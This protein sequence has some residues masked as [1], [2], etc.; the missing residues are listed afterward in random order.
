VGAAG[1]LFAMAIMFVPKSAFGAMLHGGFFNLSTPA[2][3]DQQAAVA[4][5]PS[6]VTVATLNNIGPHLVTRDTVV[7]WDGTGSTP[8]LL[9]PWVVANPSQ[10]QFTF[11]SIAQETNGRDG[12]RFLERHGYRVAFY[13]HG[14]YVLHREDLPAQRGR[15]LG[16]RR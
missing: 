13:R 6:G 11:A 5:V 4:A 12:I 10:A 8:P 14:Y 7:L 2:I 1:L 16:G 3:E 9:A 15:S